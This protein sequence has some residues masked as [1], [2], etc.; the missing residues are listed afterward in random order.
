MFCPVSQSEYRDGFTKCSDCGADLVGQLADDSEATFWA[1][2]DARVRTAICDKLDAAKIPHEDD[3]VESQFMPAFRQFIYRIQIHRKDHEAAL[4]AIRDNYF[5]QPSAR[6]SPGV[7]LNRNSDLLRSSVAQRDMW[8]RVIGSDP[9]SSEPDSES[10]IATD[11][12]ASSDVDESAEAV[13]DDHLENFNP[14]DATSQVWS[15][16][17]G[18]TAQSISLSLREVGIGCVVNE[19]QGSFNVSVERA[20]EIRAKEIVR[21]IIDHTPRE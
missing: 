13:P 17:G 4:N 9:G 5:D 16:A 19:M 7:V 11:A 12:L 1:G 3:S 18:S 15:G 2:Q 21:E 20:S 6:P 14:D 10:E 8:G